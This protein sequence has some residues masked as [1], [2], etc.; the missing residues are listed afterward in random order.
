MR[1][2]VGVAMAILI[3]LIT[4]GMLRKGLSAQQPPAEPPKEDY[5]RVHYTKYEFRIPMRD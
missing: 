5:V 1:K 2:P 3:L 4:S